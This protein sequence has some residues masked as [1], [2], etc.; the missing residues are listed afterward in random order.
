M[1]ALA[2]IRVVDLTSSIAGAWCSRLLADFGADVV[3][4]EPPEGCPLRR[5]EPFAVDAS[6]G[7]RFSIAAAY[8]MA[9][10]QSVVI[11]EANGEGAA[12]LAALIRRAHVVLTSDASGRTLVEERPDQVHVSITPHGLDGARA[13]WA[14]NDLT[15]WALSGWAS[16]NGLADRPPLKGSG[17]N[18]SMVAGIGAFAAT[19]AALVAR[20]RDGQGQR[21]DVAETEVLATTFSPSMLRSLY[22]GRP[23]AR[24]ARVDMTTGPVPVRDGYFALTISRAHFWR[25]AMN[26]LGLTDLAEDQ[27]FEASWYRQQHRD[28]YVPR[29]E[30][31]MAQWTKMDLFDALATLRVVAGPVLT[32]DEL[33][34]NPHLRAREYFTRPAS[35][36]G[37]DPEFPGA[38]FRMSGTPWHLERPAPRTGADLEAVRASAVEPALGGDE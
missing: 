3:V 23:E 20:D 28:D 13:G 1:G 18:A 35:G 6:T 7:E 17:S 11:D 26:L 31:R 36:G 15:A 9:N 33:T 38:P 19:L 37:A 2:D 21:V 29:V 24:D 34:A 25:D 14:G 12:L 16:V 8:V 32:M 4:V 10:K 22:Q 27:R 30:E 5:L